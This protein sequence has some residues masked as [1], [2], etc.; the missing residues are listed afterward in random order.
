[1]PRLQYKSFA[2]PDEI[3]TFPHGQA[4]VVGLDES[5]VGRAMYEPG[6]RWSTDMA[7]I[8]GTASCQLHHLGYS[9]SGVMHVVSE[10]GQAIDIPPG[11]VYEIPPG[12]DAWVVGDEPWVTVE[13]T[14]ART[15]GLVPEGFGEGVVMTVLF[16]DIVG[17]TATLQM[18]GNTAWRDLLFAHNTRLRDQLNIFR[19]REVK[20]TGDGF[21]AVFDS[22]TRAVRCGAA[23]ARAARGMDLPI[24]V[25]IHTGEVEMVG[26]DARGLAVHAAARVMA[27]A[28]PDEVLVSS[29][30]Y[31]LLEGSGLNLEEAGTHEMKGL[32]G[33][34]R[35]F[36]LVVAAT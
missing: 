21:L 16:T 13:W 10:D 26:N 17:S 36:R 3:R 12:H 7:A 34:R 14:S 25:G 22:A 31:D 33:V 18:M 8:A 28:G 32:P 27:V 23:M 24:R 2:T 19:G 4:E 15:F 5:M 20:T 11:S 30:T 35:V 6:W 29:T 1:M 9:I